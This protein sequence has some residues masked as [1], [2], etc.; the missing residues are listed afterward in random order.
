VWRQ[1]KLTTFHAH[2]HLLQSLGGVH[3]SGCVSSGAED[4][5]Y[6]D[7]SG[8]L[9]ILNHTERLATVLRSRAMAIGAWGDTPVAFMLP[10]IEKVVPDA[11]YVLWPRASDSWAASF[12]SFFCGANTSANR[13]YLVHA[14]DSMN[15]SHEQSG[16]FEAK[17]FQLSYGG[18]NP[19]D[20]PYGRKSVVSQNMRQV[21]RAYE[22]HMFNI[23]NYFSGQ[24][25]SSRL[26][27]LDYH[28]TRSAAG[29][30]A[31]SSSTFLGTRSGART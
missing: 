21:K 23:Q 28:R 29:G 11:K 2:V 9:S 10:L 7:S 24:S 26:L 22:R 20:F 14:S 3:E 12:Q 25:R 4:K 16:I 1:L 18:C 15:F 17:A 30:C 6:P 19:C 27:L 31:S 8:W 5:Q 13:E